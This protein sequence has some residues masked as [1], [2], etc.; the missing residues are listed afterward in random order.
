MDVSSKVGLASLLITLSYPCR[1]DSL[2]VVC[3]WQ[4][5]KHT[6]AGLGMWDA[7]MPKATTPNSPI[8]YAS[9]DQTSTQHRLDDMHGHA[10]RLT[11]G[12]YVRWAKVKSHHGKQRSRIASSKL[13]R[14]TDV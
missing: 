2:C 12:C 9:S 5:P 6:S 14:E 11:T 10:I 1:A 7:Y 3:W 13:A 8:Y 4:R